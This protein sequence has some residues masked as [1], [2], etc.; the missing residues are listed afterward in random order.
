LRI[1][2]TILDTKPPLLQFRRLRISA[3]R[4][5]S[6]SARVQPPPDASSPSR[7][8]KH[9][10]AILR[11]V[12]RQGRPSLP[13]ACPPLRRPSVRTPEKPSY[14]LGSSA[15]HSFSIRICLCDLLAMHFQ[16]TPLTSCVCLAAAPI[17]LTFRMRPGPT[18]SGYSTHSNNYQ[19]SEEGTPASQ[20]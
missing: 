4:P 19:V 9:Q 11:Q 2:G 5:N 7:R 12:N 18:S 15:P 6:H 3:S 14:D 10:L 8:T 16:P 13:R 1:T 17:L 20:S